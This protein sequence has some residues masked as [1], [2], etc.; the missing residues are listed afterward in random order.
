MSCK[1]IVLNQK[2]M[3]FLKD[4]GINISDANFIT[5]HSGLQQ[6]CKEFVEYG[7]ANYAYSLTDLLIHIPTVNQYF[8]KNGPKYIFQLRRENNIFIAGYYLDTGECGN[9][10]SNKNPLDAVFSLWKT[11]ILNQYFLAE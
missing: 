9:S 8:D 6:S 2:E 7:F 10:V 5:S 3:Q 1:K 4:Q 11:C